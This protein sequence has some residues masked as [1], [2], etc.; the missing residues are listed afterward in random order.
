MAASWDD[1]GDE[2]ALLSKR[3]FAEAT[4]LVPAKIDALMRAGLPTT[5]N[6]F[7][8]RGHGY[9]LKVAFAWLVDNHGKDDEQDPLTVAR[10]RKAV[11]EAERIE[12][13]NRKASGELV[14]V[15]VVHDGHCTLVV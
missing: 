15:S 10:Q 6:A 14:D 7:P 5:P 12:I 9:D 3:A 13:A 1:I 11:A 8:R 4:G 2:P